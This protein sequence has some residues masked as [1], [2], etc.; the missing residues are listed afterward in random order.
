MGPAVDAVRPRFT[1]AAIL[2]LADTE[3]K[4]GPLGGPVFG[5]SNSQRVEEWQL[6]PR[7]EEFGLPADWLVIMPASGQTMFRMVT[8]EQQPPPEDFL[9]DR[10]R[11]RPRL[12]EDL[13]ADH[14]G[15]SMFAELAQ[16]E[17]IMRR[18]PKLVAGV[19]LEAGHG[20]SLARTLPDLDGHHTVWGEADDL[21]QL[22]QYVHVNRGP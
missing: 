3:R 2:R 13:E 8:H 6:P 10:A 4:S 7:P 18:Y 21:A 12:D 16:A 5:W 19:R 15:S 14:L 17:A 11:S 22:V 20:F 9:S 1:L